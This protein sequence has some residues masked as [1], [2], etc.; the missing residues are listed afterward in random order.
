[1]HADPAVYDIVLPN[2][3]TVKEFVSGVDPVIVS[4]NRES[5]RNV[6]EQRLIDAKLANN[7]NVKVLALN[8]L[9]ALRK[10]GNLRL[11]VWAEGRLAILHLPSTN[12]FIVVS[13]QSTA[14]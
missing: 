4:V 10:S 3:M 12:D 11:F 5:Y 9:D 6:W 1:M 13:M 14:M 8:I 2:G 7:E